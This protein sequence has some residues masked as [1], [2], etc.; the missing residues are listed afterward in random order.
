MRTIFKKKKF[1]PPNH[2]N[3]PSKVVHNPTRPRV[4]NPASFC[5]VQLR[6]FFSLVFFLIFEVVKLCRMNLESPDSTEEIPHSK[7]LICLFL[8]YYL[9]L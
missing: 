5:F 3:L 4:F 8:G 1:C 7:P 9:D 6:Q 2:K